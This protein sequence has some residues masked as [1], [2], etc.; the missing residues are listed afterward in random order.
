VVLGRHPGLVLENCGGGG[1][2]SEFAML[3]TLQ[4]QSTSDQQDPLLYPAIAVRPLAHILPEQAGNWAYPQ[5]DMTDEE[6]IFAMAAG[7][8]GRL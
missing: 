8:A 1:M 6:I 3:A 2:R 7:L 4:L 5:P